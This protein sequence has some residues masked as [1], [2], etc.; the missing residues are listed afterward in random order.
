M[1]KFRLKNTQKHCKDL[2]LYVVKEK[3]KREQLSKKDDYGELVAEETDVRDF[4]KCNPW[5]DE[6]T[7]KAWLRRELNKNIQFLHHLV[8][9]GTIEQQVS[10][11]HHENIKA[12]YEGL[13]D[14][15]AIYGEVRRR[16]W[17][18]GDALGKIGMIFNFCLLRTVC[19]DPMFFK[20]DSKYQMSL[21]MHPCSLIDVFIKQIIWDGV[22]EWEA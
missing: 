13:M 3:E 6:Q 12:T 8:D 5:Q 18:I 9:F 7:I 16:G 4:V 15:Q 14:E 10:L 11:Y 20:C 1:S 19:S 22:H 17:L 21:K 2:K